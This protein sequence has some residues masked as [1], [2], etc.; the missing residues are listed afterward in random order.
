[1]ELAEE[2]REGRRPRPPE[3]VV[4]HLPD[5]ELRGG[6]AVGIGQ[7]DRLAHAATRLAHRGDVADKVRPE[8]PRIGI[9]VAP[10]LVRVGIPPQREV[11]S[12]DQDRRTV[13]EIHA[14]KV[15]QA[16]PH[17]VAHHPLAVLHLPN[18]VIGME[19]RMV[20]PQAGDGSVGKDVARRLECRLVEVRVAY[21]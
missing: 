17:P 5:A 2:H 3:S 19:E 7:L 8:A 4:G 10:A 18:L 21:E 6:T 13:I 15:R 16:I 1:M 14:I 12:R 9:G 20:H 11:P